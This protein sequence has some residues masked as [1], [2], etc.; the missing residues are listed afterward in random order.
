MTHHNNSTDQRLLGMDVSYIQGRSVNFERAAKM[1]AAYCFI[2][3][4][5]GKTAVDSNYNHN[6]EEA[7][8]AGLLRGIYYYL[9]PE[10]AA[11]IG[12]AADRTPEGQARRFAAMLKLD[13]ELGAVV[14]VEAKNL[15]PDE[16]KR[17]VDEFQKHDPYGR[18]ITIYTANWYWNAG[19]G[20]VETAVSWAANHPLWTAQY[21][22]NK[23]PIQPTDAYHVAIP[24]PWDNYTF[25]Q[26]TSMGGFL[27]HHVSKH[28]DL[29]YFNGSLADLQAWAGMATKATEKIPPVFN[30]VNATYGLNL[31]N[32][33]SIQGTV[34]KVMAWAETVEILEDG[35]WVL[36]KS[37]DDTGYAS[38]TYLS[39]EKP[40]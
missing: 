7:G 15:S 25:H 10:S 30:Y 29:N 16:V 33:P 4:G 12:T 2:R 8:N 3:A 14:D 9:Y 20:Y 32:K 36:L 40:S 31:R 22:S 6:Y 28:L 35:D 11:T 19:R 23:E 13:A 38:R 24:K 37:G 39:N 1:G 26:W 21:T 18:P 34:I 5:S 27:L 17:F